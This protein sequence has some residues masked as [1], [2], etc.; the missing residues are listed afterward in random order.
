MTVTNPIEFFTTIVN[1]CSNNVL[2]H[3]KAR[4]G[5][6]ANSC[7]IMSLQ[8]PYSLLPLRSLTV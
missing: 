2:L 8:N 4:W 3:S 7:V 5:D 1:V 6:L